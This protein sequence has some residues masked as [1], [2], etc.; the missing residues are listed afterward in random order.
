MNMGEHTVPV[1][2]ITANVGSVFENRD[3][4]EKGWI[5]ETVGTITRL[6]PKFVALHFQESGGKESGEESLENVKDFTRVFL[7]QSQLKEKFDK[8]RAWFDQDYHKQEQYTALGC[9]YLVSK[10]LEDASLWNFEGIS[11]IPQ[12]P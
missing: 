3:G 5:R 11:T 7:G 10:S 1:L 2:L 12:T 4:L 8:V 6:K 9:I